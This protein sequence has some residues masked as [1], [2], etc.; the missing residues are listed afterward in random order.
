[1]KKLLAI[2]SA[3]ILAFL[4]WITIYHY[5]HQ[6][7]E[8]VVAHPVLYVRLAAVY[9]GDL[10]ASTAAFIRKDVL[11]AGAPSFVNVPVLLAHEHIDLDK[12]I[13]RTIA[14]R[15]AY[16][17]TRKQYYIEIDAKIVDPAAISKIKDGLYYSISVGF[18][19][20]NAV[21]SID[22]L[23]P[24]ECPHKPGEYYKVNGQWVIARIIPSKIT[25][26]EVSFVNVPG[27]AGARILDM[28]SDAQ[29]LGTSK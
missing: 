10:N 4:T 16:D 12:C 26:L 21:C 13:G 2:T 23:F 25:G 17:T 20:D 7:Q 11:E 14:A 22:N 24:K 29:S 6:S 19:I 28:S 15:L 27:S 3:L 18:H 9:D 8:V 5:N 1:M